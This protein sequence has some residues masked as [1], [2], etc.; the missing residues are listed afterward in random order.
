MGDGELQRLDALEVM[1]VDGVQAT[2]KARRASS[3]KIR[4]RLDG[5]GHEIDEH[6]VFVLFSVFDELAAKIAVD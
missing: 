5:I 3:R 4:D 1:A 6:D 2:G